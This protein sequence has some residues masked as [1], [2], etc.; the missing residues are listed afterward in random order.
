MAICR[1][2]SSNIFIAAGFIFMLLRSAISKM[3]IDFDFYVVRV[4]VVTITII[5]PY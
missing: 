4:I 2:I 5:I 1:L 3:F